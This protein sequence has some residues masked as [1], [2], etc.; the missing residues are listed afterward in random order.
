MSAFF[1]EDLPS[2]GNRSGWPWTEQNEYVATTGSNNLSCPKISIITPSYNQGEYIEETIRS[3]LLQNYANLEYI[4]IDGGST[5][6]T[7]DILQMYDSWIDHWVSEPDD[8][9]SDAIN[10][11]FASASGDIYA[12]LNS[13]DYYAEG[14]LHT[15]AKAFASSRAEVGAI[16]GTGHKVDDRG[17]VVY[18]PEVPELSHEAFLD[19]MSYGHFMQPA[20]FFRR[21]AWEVC[22][23][24]RTDLR[25]PMDVDLW[26]R[27]SDAFEFSRVDETIAYAH[28]HD[29]AK[30]TGERQHMRA[31]TI[32]LAAEHGGYDVAHR[33]AMKMADDLAEANRKVR[34]ITDNILY[35]RVVG[36]AYRFIRSLTNP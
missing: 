29:E 6:Q 12:W 13:D 24:L 15:M 1:L 20:C 36:P 9:Q 34:L 11:G 3:V 26:L 27:M 8:G 7:I 33:E 31:E 22:G 19:W 2:T 35:R 21:Q 25:Y 5:D 30:T 16:V 14:A 4:V 32:L 18:T 28:Q 23:P 10:K 17:E